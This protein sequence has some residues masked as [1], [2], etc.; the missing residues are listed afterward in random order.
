MMLSAMVE[1]TSGSTPRLISGATTTKRNTTPSS[2]I[3]ARTASTS[4][5]R[6][7]TP[8]HF[9]AI[10]ARKAGTMTNSPCAKLMVCDV[11]HSSVK[12]IAASA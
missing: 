2:S 8:N 6:N 5:P 11:C 7:G 4:A 9:M 10:S 12:P 1:T 3:E